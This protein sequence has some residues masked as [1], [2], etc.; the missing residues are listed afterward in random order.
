MDWSHS[1]EPQLGQGIKPATQ[2]HASD[3]KSNLRPFHEW[4]D[5]LTTRKYWPG[6]DLFSMLIVKSERIIIN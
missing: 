6:P 3:Q 4:A 1:F 2:A 5:T